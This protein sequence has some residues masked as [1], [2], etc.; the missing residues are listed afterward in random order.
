MLS[1]VEVEV[2]GGVTKTKQP[3]EQGPVGTERHT[4]ARQS[5]GRGRGEERLQRGDT[6]ENMING[7]FGGSIQS[8][9]S[10][11]DVEGLA[12]MSQY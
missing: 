10:R 8:F 9:Q 5:A 3:H 4:L 2:V 7:L 12:A 1:V 6:C 11:Q